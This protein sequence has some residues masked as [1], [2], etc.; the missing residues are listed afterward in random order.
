MLA[1]DFGRQ[2]SVKSVYLPLHQ[3]LAQRLLFL[4]YWPV[5]A[6]SADTLPASGKRAGSDA[7]FAFAFTIRIRLC[8]LQIDD[9][10]TRIAAHRSHR[11]CCRSGPI[12]LPRTSCC[13]LSVP[14][15]CACPC[16]RLKERRCIGDHHGERAS[17]VKLWLSQHE[18]Q[19][20]HLAMSAQVPGCQLS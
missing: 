8:L 3:S 14:P 15:A 20:I 5:S 4:C 12:D 19:A 18:R 13:A 6:Q 16:A 9:S 17:A 7:S 2:S 10:L 11:R 1:W